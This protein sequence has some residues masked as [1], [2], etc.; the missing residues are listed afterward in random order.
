[1]RISILS[2]YEDS[3]QNDSGASVRIINLAKGLAATGNKV[4]VIL[5]KFHTSTEYVDKI[6]VYGLNGFL[7]K[8]LLKIIGKIGKIEK[9][10]ALYFFDFL[11][12]FRA[13]RLVQNVDIVQIEQP[14]LSILLTPFMRTMKKP[15]AIDCHDVF[16]AL[17]VKHTSLV[18]R[19]LETFLEKIA[20]RNADLILTVSEKEKKLLVSL[21]FSTQKIIVVPNGV[22][23]ELF[24]RH[25][26]L[27]ETRR[28]YGLD[29]SQ[30]VVFV[31]N[32]AYE[33]NREAIK[34]ISSVIAP[35]VREKVKTVKFIVV[36]KKR[37]EINLPG[38]AFTGFVP[39]I[40]DLLAASN[41]GIAPLL[42]GSG[43]RLKILEYFS[44]GIPVVSTSVGAEGLS[45]KNGK[46]IFIDNN[47]ENFAEHIVQLLKD[48]TLSSN[49]GE[50]GRA[51][52]ANYDWK[53]ITSQ[54]EEEY[55][56]FTSKYPISRK[57]NA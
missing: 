42:Q 55:L 5:P 28:Q 29:G 8:S 22:N 47:F 52:A 17:R 33:P 27:Q 57:D 15:V 24:S 51:I 32:L 7:P 21:G 12:A 23:T 50:A 14:A 49:I 25:S 37:T 53:K 30:T 41:V 1:M 18:R 11:F 44:S 9:P 36:G 2:A 19:I 10:S 35:K 3:M 56:Q 40:A 48:K 34:L 13:S 4:N 54:L 38:I 16:Q 39:N 6:S 46:N 43:T 26:D 45:I 31:G 20:Y